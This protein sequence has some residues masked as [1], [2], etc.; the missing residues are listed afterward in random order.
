MK[1]D[2]FGGLDPL[3]SLTHSRQGGSALLSR[4]HKVFQ[5]VVLTGLAGHRH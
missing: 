3:L 1:T 5:W 4:I 2:D